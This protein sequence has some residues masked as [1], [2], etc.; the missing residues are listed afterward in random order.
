MLGKLHSV[1]WLKGTST[2]NQ[3]FCSMKNLRVSGWNVPI[4]QIYDSFVAPTPRFP[5]VGKKTELPR[6]FPSL[7]RL[8]RLCFACNTG[9]TWC[10]RHRDRP[11]SK[12]RGGPMEVPWGLG[13]MTVLGWNRNA[14][15][16][17]G[18]NLKLVGNSQR[19]RGKSVS[20]EIH[21][22]FT[23]N[24][25]R[26]GHL[27]TWK[28]LAFMRIFLWFSGN[29]GWPQKPWKHMFQTNQQN[30]MANHGQP[31]EKFRQPPKCIYIYKS[32]H[33][34]IYICIR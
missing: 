29:P 16:I 32:Y 17:H 24:C 25:L 1:D 18:G 28:S 7:S 8:A 23:G 10:L 30:A 15:E 4:N 3:W 11:T 33:I 2:G 21:G 26:I 14:L 13:T 20:W 9:R 34:S 6:F 27:Y 5:L 31:Q 19:T 22:Q 12:K